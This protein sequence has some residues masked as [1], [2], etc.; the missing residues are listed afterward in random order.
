MFSRLSYF[1]VFK[2]IKNVKPPKPPSNQECCGDGCRHCVWTT[3]FQ[4]LKKY[5]ESKRKINI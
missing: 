1:S 3:Y 5:Q 2:K 4:D